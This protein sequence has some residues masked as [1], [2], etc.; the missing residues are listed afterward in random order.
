MLFRGCGGDVVA[1]GGRR[2]NAAGKKRY[3]EDRT[4][5]GYLIGGSGGGGG[6]GLST[7]CWFVYRIARGVSSGGGSVR[8]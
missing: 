3:G 6:G 7:A 1:W 4:R 5:D 8:R 2:Y